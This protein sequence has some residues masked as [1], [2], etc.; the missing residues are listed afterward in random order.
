MNNT[1]NPYQTPS[2]EVTPTDIAGV[3]AQLAS[4]WARLG[5]SIIDTVI[6]M[7]ITIPVM[8]VSGV[9]TDA[10]SGKQPGLMFSLMMLVISLVAFVLIHGKFLI[11][12]GQTIGKMAVGI[13]I[14]DL[15][16][17]IP[18]VGDYLKRY[19][20]FFLPAQVPLIGSLFAI[21]NVLFIF[22]KEKRCIHDLAA[23]TRVLNAK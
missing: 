16:G 6:M 5:A 21:V 10:M 20:V 17:N 3:D 8:M 7:A 23:G 18:S 12:R 1:Q 2:A 19:A 22:G 9:F 13:K 15:N 14:V 11:D 4:R